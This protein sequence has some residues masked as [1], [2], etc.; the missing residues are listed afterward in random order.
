M[1]TLTILSLL[2]LSQL[3][4]NTEIGKVNSTHSLIKLPNG[5]D[6]ILIRNVEKKVK[7]IEFTLG[8]RT[9]NYKHSEFD[10]NKGKK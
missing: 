8:E 4:A 2:F 10:Y 6:F 3:N 9:I 1:K 7:P 5:N